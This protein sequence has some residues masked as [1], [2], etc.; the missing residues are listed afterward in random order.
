MGAPRTVVVSKDG[1]QVFFLRSQSC[2]DPVLC[3]WVLDPQTGS[4]QLLADPSVLGPSEDADLPAAELARRERARESANG[5]VSYSLDRAAQTAVFALGGS[6]FRVNTATGTT[7]A[8]HA[9]NDVYDPRISPDGNHVAYIS[10]QTLRLTCLAKGCLA[11]GGDGASSDGASSDI[12][13][14]DDEHALVSWGRAE[15]I[16]AEEMSRTRGYWWS[17]DSDALLATR[18]DES[19][20]ERRWISD[21][22]HPEREPNEVRYPAAG[23]ANATVDLAL[24]KLDG[25]QSTIDWREGRFEY[26]ANVKWDTSGPPLLLR[27]PRNQRSLSIAEL[28]LQTLAVTEVHQI[29]D[30]HWVE[31]VPGSPTRS[32]H[33]LLTIEDRSDH[34]DNRVLCLNGKVLSPSDAQVR[35]IVAVQGDEALVTVSTDPTEIHLVV[36]SLVGEPPRQLTDQPGV[37]HAVSGGTTLAIISSLADQ[38]QTSTSL[39]RWGAEEV[40]GESGTVTPASFSPASI[41][42]LAEEP[43]LKAKPTYLRLGQS[44]LNAALFLPQDHDG[45]TPLPVLM[46]PYG[47]PHAQRVLKTQNSHLVSQWFANQGFAVLVV[48]GRGTPGRGP[49]FERAVWGDLAQPVLDDQIEAL[50]AAAASYPFLD[51]GRVGIRGWSFGGYLSAL[52]VLRRPDRFQAAV[53]GAPVTSWRLYDTHYTERYL[54]HPD[55]YPENYERSD[56]LDEAAG[57]GSPLLIIH[58]LADD[59]VVAAHTL[60]LSSALLAAGRQHQVLPLSGVTHMTPQ[61]VVAENLLLLQRDFL[62]DHLAAA[63]DS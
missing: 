54:G 61:A 56:L 33:G 35:S 49:K 44:E 37:H 23:T 53:A 24:V 60:L 59:N 63:R 9:S 27:Q 25:Q 16:A 1:T 39:H 12:L 4:E 50:D 41:T 6:L 57:L 7:T 55:T 58:G 21:P 5:I 42:N 43:L 48:D 10:G 46:D 13:L 34:L 51:L 3:L 38:S 15:F 11:H 47:G 31:L 14:K 26:L 29:Q 30:E 20:L 2:D 18:V 45:K 62:Q 32:T 40:K 52:A 36:L 22:A 8:L 17:P 28:D 19:P